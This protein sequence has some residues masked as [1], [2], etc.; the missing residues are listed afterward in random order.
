MPRIDCGRIYIYD[1]DTHLPT[2][3]CLVIWQA[4][5]IDNE[6][7]YSVSSDPEEYGLAILD[8][9]QAMSLQLFRRRRQW[10]RQYDTLIVDRASLAEFS[11]GPGGTCWVAKLTSG[12]IL[13]KE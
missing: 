13:C 10:R 12:G 5:H 4:E 6:L 1:F 11:K 9:E 7:W 2:T 8:Q 3:E